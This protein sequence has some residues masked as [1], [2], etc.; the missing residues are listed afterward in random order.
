[1]AKRQSSGYDFGHFP[2]LVML[3]QD[4]LQGHQDYQKQSYAN[5]GDLV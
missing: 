5:E 3:F 1:M 2:Y 4:D